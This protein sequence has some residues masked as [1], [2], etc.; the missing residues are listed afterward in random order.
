MIPNTNAPTRNNFQINFFRYGR[1]GKNI[2]LTTDHGGWVVLSEA[3]YLRILN[4]DIPEHLYDTLSSNGIILTEDNIN[5]IIEKYKTRYERFFGGTSLHLVI[6]TIRCNQSCVYCHSNAVNPLSIEKTM[7]QKTADRVL[8][9]IFQSPS[10]DIIIEFQGGESLMVFDCVKYVVSQAKKINEKIK[11]TLNFVIVTNLTLLK[12]DMIEF[13]S[14]NKIKITTSLDGPRKLHN[15]NRQMFGGGDTYDHVIKNIEKLKKKGINV[16]MIM[17]T[18]RY[19]LSCWKEIIDEYIKH[20]QSDIRLGYIDYLG[21]ARSTWNKI[22]YTIDEF[23]DFWKKSTDYIFS[24]HKKGVLLLES[25]IDIILKK[26][27]NS[28]DPNFLDLRSPCGIIIG[29]LAYNYN[30]DIYSC[31]EGRSDEYYL[32]GNV[33][34]N[35]IG[36]VLRSRKA[37]LLVTSSINENY[38]CD[39]CVYKP[40]CGL[41]PVLTRAVKNRL[42][43]AVHHDNHCKRVKFMFDYV[44]DK[45]INEPKD[46]KRLFLGIKLKNMLD[47][48]LYRVVTR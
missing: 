24:Y 7:D 16:G 37:K 42:F 28:F 36:S 29:Q 44:I 39:A 34:K 4:Y 1:R 11:K 17:V 19:S 18:T 20:G 2:L 14:K 31:D 30:G 40:F 3:E 6:P 43:T 21:V 15:K 47:S 23:L 45:I 10:P 33:K 9:F 25:N 22:G 26:L 32:L 8:D 35:D 12:D 41:C 27:Y 38:L 5:S 46:I 48:S 13:I